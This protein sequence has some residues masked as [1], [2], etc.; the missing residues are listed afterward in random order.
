ME[1]GGRLEAEFGTRGT[2]AAGGDAVLIA[3]GALQSDGERLPGLLSTPAL[4]AHGV[5]ASLA[6]GT[7][8]PAFEIAEQLAQLALLILLNEGAVVLKLACLSGRRLN[9]AADNNGNQL[10]SKREPQ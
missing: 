10:F 6:E 3:G 7:V 9:K 2:V 4:G 8:S 1:E 5:A